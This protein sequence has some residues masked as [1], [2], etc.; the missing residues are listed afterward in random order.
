MY[1]E[2]NTCMYVKQ[3]NGKPGIEASK[4]C[5]QKTVCTNETNILLPG[6]PTTP[7]WYGTTTP[8]SQ[9]E[10]AATASLIHH[11]HKWWCAH[12]ER[13]VFEYQRCVRSQH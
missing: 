9:F 6:N 13:S 1:V 3:C 8:K 5:L 12:C 7:T 2:E 4:T 10:D 11:K